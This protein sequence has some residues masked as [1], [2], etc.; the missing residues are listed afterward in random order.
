MKRHSETL[1]GISG[2]LFLVGFISSKLKNIPIFLIT[3]ILSPVSLAAYL[4][5]YIAWY[6]ASIFYPDHPRKQKHWYGFAQF[7]EQ[8][9]VAAVL[10][11]IATIMYLVAPVYIIPTA[12]LYTISNLI[13]SISEYHKKENPL[14]NDVH[15]SSIR[16]RIYLRYTILVA[17]SSAL[18]AIAETVA[19][20]FPQTA[21]LVI[22]CSSILGAGLTVASIYHWGKCAFGNYPPDIV[23]HSYRRLSEQLEFPLDY[24]TQPSNVYGPKPIEENTQSVIKQV[25]INDDT[26]ENLNPSSTITCL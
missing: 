10:G 1:D 17:T 19:Y 18:T 14:P 13:W 23:N 2:Y 16:Q 12:W 5:G 26:Y 21:L 6:A 22:A 8:Y 25:K 3:A 20:L 4:I 15:Y 7:R 9:Q 11:T 24:G